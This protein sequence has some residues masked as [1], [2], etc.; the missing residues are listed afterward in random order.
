MKEKIDTWAQGI[1]IQNI[2]YRSLSQEEI[3]QHQF[4]ESFLVRPSPAGNAICKTVYPED[5][6]WIAERLNFAAKTQKYLE[7]IL[8]DDRDSIKQMRRLR[9]FL[10]LSLPNH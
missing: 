8:H 2:K 9:E 7:E 3:S 5:A 6:K 1:F 4:E 10:K